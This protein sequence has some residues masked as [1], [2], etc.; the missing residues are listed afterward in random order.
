[1]THIGEAPEVP[2]LNTISTQDV[3]DAFWRG[4]SDFTRAPAFGLFFGCIFSIIGI[5]IYLQMFVLGT[6]YWALLLAAGFPLIGPFVAVGLYEVSRRMESGE[7]L[8]WAE[9]LTIATRP[10]SQIPSMAFVAL[11]FFLVWVYLAHLV[12]ALTFG[13]K[14]LTNVMSS[15]DILFSSAGITMLLVGSLVGAALAFLLFAV[16]VIGVPILLDRPLDVVTAMITS[17]RAVAANPQPMLA[18]A[19]IIAVLT[20]VAMVP[21]F[22]GMIIVFPILAHAS[23]HM[24]RKIVSP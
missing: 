20:F 17:F 6:T 10:N 24:Y 23:W 2:E 1:M 22:L 8:E 7:A 3:S 18:W 5:V 4:V 14:P 13:L 15:P 21:F 12:F 11:F 16:T 19:A 9:I